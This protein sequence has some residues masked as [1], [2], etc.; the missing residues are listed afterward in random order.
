MQPGRPRMAVNGP[1]A[2]YGTPLEGRAELPTQPAPAPHHTQERV[3]VEGG[4]EIPGY[5]DYEA[6]VQQLADYEAAGIPTTHPDRLHLVEALFKAASPPKLEHGSTVEKTVERPAPSQE[7]APQPQVSSHLPPPKKTVL[8]Q[9]RG[10]AKPR[11]QAI[12]IEPRA[13]RHSLPSTP[14]GDPEEAHQIRPSRTPGQGFAATSSPEARRK[15]PPIANVKLL[16]AEDFPPSQRGSSCRESRGASSEPGFSWLERVGLMIVLLV[17]I[18]GSVFVVQNLHQRHGEGAS[19]LPDESRPESA[20]VPDVHRVTQAEDAIIEEVLATTAAAPA[21]AMATSNPSGAVLTDREQALIKER[22]I[23]FHKAVSG[24]AKLPHLLDGM[25]WLD[26]LA[27]YYQ[28]HPLEPVELAIEPGLTVIETERGPYY[29][30]TGRY[31]G[32]EPMAFFAAKQNGE[33]LL[34]WPS[35][36]GY[37]E[38]NWVEFLLGKPDVPVSFRV[39]AVEASS[40]SADS[41]AVRLSVFRSKVHRIAKVE[42]ESAAGRAMAKLL[43]TGDGNPQRWRINLSFRASAQGLPELVVTDLLGANWLDVPAL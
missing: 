31:A 14:P 37:S 21:T 20:S 40:S 24:E 36:C 15:A 43:A 16:S 11:Q 25:D 34:D 41:I 7:R 27:T 5:V 28:T 8:P 6:I 35:L 3:T 2:S 39:V 32:G 4:H 1:A 22:V 19:A 30:G 42:R 18:L 10:S 26:P 33:F 17:S 23:A 12:D 38:T 13:L 29:R 9:P